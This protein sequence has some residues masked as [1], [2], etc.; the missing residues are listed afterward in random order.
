[1][2]GYYKYT[3]MH[4][5]INRITLQRNDRKHCVFYYLNL[6][7]GCSIIGISCP[8]KCV[9]FPGWY[10]SILKYVIIVL[11]YLY[12]SIGFSIWS[13]TIQNYDHL[14]LNVI[15]K[16]LALSSAGNSVN[17]GSMGPPWWFLSN[18]LRAT[19]THSLHVKNWYDHRKKSP[20][21]SS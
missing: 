12:F 3:L 6:R 11:S 1:M 17:S 7:C 5:L 8:S 21:S 2:L 19:A 4:Q 10:S 15:I 14:Y 16:G 20:C 18:H 13:I 9:R